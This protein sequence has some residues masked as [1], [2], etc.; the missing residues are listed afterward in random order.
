MAAAAVSVAM[1]TVHEDNHTILD[2]N[3]E[4]DLPRFL[5]SVLDKTDQVSRTKGDHEILEQGI[6]VVNQMVCL[7]HTLRGSS[8]N[9]SADDEEYLNNPSSAFYDIS[10]ALWQCL[11]LAS[12]PPSLVATMFVPW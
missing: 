4:F 3:V 8:S 11:V 7:L 1:Q 12:L 9:I 6:V 10:S 2:F 5:S